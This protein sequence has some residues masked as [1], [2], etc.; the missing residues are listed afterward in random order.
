M[1]KTLTVENVPDV[2][3]ERLKSSADMH[4]RSLNSEALAWLETA[5][6]LRKVP[7]EL[8]LARA[9]ILRESLPPAEFNSADIDAAKRDGGP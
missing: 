6:F 2:V 4:R 9:R 8:R 7:P 1:A 5:L 3:Y